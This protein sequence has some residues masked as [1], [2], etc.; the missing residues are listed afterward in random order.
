MFLPFESP[1][2]LCIVLSFVTYLIS[3]DNEL[4]ICSETKILSMQRIL[5]VSTSTYVTVRL[6]ELGYLAAFIVF[7]TG[8]IVG[9]IT[10]RPNSAVLLL[11]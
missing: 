8:N 6:I 5:V 3:V 7:D 10:E 2:R 11:I 9:V 4:A 1:R